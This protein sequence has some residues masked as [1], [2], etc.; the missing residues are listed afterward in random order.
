MRRCC[1]LARAL[2][3][4]FVVAL[5]AAALVYP[6]GSWTE[7]Q[8]IGFAWY[9]NFWCDLLRSH[10]INGADNSLGKLLA[11]VG[12]AALGLAMLPYWWVAAGLL[13]RGR[14]FWVAGFGVLSAVALAGLAAWPSDEQPLLHGVVAL[15]SGVTG[16]ACAA[17][18]VAARLPDETGA[19]LR[20]VSGALALGLGSLNAALYV[21]VAYAHGR[22]TLVQP[23]V[24]KLATVALL[25]WMSSTLLVADRRAR[26][27]PSFR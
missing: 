4:G 10:A 11:S 14:R 24:Q 17:V 20:R 21:Y 16:I 15:C 12:F 2:L 5:L 9:R 8:G 23:L 26:R 6:G 27:E 7:P 1:W 19:S 25:I 18:C 13:P 3:L 22:E